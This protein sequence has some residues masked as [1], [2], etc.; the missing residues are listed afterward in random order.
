M[1]HFVKQVVSDA[2]KAMYNLAFDC[3]LYPDQDTVHKL[4]DEKPGMAISVGSK[5]Q[6][7]VG[8]NQDFS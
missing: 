1:S 3:L 6:G 2:L 5:L 7:I 8:T 4:F